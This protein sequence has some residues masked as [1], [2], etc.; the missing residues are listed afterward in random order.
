MRYVY[1][2][3]VALF[4]T[5]HYNGFGLEVGKAPDAPRKGNLRCRIRRPAKPKIKAPGVTST[6]GK[7]KGR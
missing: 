5:A 3:L 4:A 7:K 1:G 6:G 2:Q